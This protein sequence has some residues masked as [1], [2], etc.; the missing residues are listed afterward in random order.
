MAQSD[1]LS[2]H[3]LSAIIVHWLE[4]V[5]KMATFSRF[6]RGFRNEKKILKAF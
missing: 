5:Y 3:A 6:G 2:Y 4:A 1:W